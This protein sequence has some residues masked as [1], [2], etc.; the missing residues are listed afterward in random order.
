MKNQ[1]RGKTTRNQ[2]SQKFI[3]VTHNVAQE[4]KNK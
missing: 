3:L 1:E 2:E 4:E